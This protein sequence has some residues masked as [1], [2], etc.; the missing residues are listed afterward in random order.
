MNNGR[1]ALF[2]LQLL[3]YLHGNSFPAPAE[4]NRKNIFII[5]NKATAERPLIV[6]NSARSLA[7]RRCVEIRRKGPIINESIHMKRDG[8]ARNMFLGPKEQ[9]TRGG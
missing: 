7:K 2:S 9:A 5:E 6:Q 8:L 4:N 3:P 1:S